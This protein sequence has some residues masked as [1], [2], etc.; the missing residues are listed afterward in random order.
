[1]PPPSNSAPGSAPGSPSEARGAKEGGATPGKPAAA[2]KA[3]APG[4]SSTSADKAKAGSPAAAAPAA[5]AGKGRFALGRRVRL[6]VG[7]EGARADLLAGWSKPKVVAT[8]QI[9]YRPG[10]ATLPEAVLALDPLLAALV[11]A[12]GP[13]RG[14]TCDVLIGDAWMLY[15]VVRADLRSLP[16]R[17]ADDVVR[18]A[19]ADVAGLPPSDVATRWQTQ[20]GGRCTIACGMPVAALPSLQT[21]LKTH[22]LHPGQIVGEFVHEYNAHRDRLWSRNAVISL[23]RETGTQL[24]V[25]ADGVLTAMSFELGVRAPEDLEVRGRGLARGAGMTLDTE[26]RFFALLPAGWTPPAPWVAVPTNA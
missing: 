2:A 25:A 14:L 19:L 12:T 26:T 1:M 11:A 7:A 13:I 17:A 22:K 4:P 16:P 23:V 20:A 8:Q 15:D 10:V 24:A 5:K 18:S 21:L 6:R 9:E 3:S